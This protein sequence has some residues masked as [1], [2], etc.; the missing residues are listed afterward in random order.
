MVYIQE[1]KT[2]KMWELHKLHKYKEMKVKNCRTEKVILGGPPF[3]C[4]KFSSYSN[5]L[6]F[7]LFCKD[8]TMLMTILSS[9]EAS[10]HAIWGKRQHDNASEENLRCLG[11]SRCSPSLTQFILH[12][13]LF[14][15]H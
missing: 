2:E 7:F 5:L 10:K 9:K 1:K 14:L 11:S 4:L 15:S 6:S 13:S 12:K 8:D 3:F